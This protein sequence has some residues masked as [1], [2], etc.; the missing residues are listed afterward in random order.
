MKKQRVLGLALL[1]D[2]YSCGSGS[3]A[4]EACT[5]YG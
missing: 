1:F 5:E 4:D 3:R 2:S